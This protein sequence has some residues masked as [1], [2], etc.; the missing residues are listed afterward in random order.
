M[1]R[2]PRLTEL[3]IAALDA[4][5]RPPTFV[6]EAELTGRRYLEDRDTVAVIEGSKDHA[7][8][9]TERWTLALGEDT[10][11]PWRIVATAAVG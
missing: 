5:S 11:T 10:A 8:T 9:F 7:T 3:R 4:E 2:G 1:V 6:V